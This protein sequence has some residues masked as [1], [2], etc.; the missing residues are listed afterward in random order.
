[1][2]STSINPFVF[3]KLR[4]IRG[5]A[6]AFRPGFP[7]VRRVTLCVVPGRKRARAPKGRE[8]TRL[9]RVYRRFIDQHD[10]DVVPYRVYPPALAAL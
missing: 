6:A 8:I 5:T 4:G 2:P 1:M 7:W 10:G 3:D 9:R